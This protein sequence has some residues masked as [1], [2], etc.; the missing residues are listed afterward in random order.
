MGGSTLIFSYIHR[1]GSFFGVQK[2]EFQYFW[3]FSDSEYFL[4]FGDFVDICF[5]YHLIGHYK[6]F[7][8]MHFRVFS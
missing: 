5:G 8:S 7:N 6:A 1:L 3:G 2:F 4:E